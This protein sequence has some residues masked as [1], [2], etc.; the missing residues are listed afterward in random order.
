M[1]IFPEGREMSYMES[2]VFYSFGDES[3]FNSL[4]WSQLSLKQGSNARL[5]SQITCDHLKSVIHVH[6]TFCFWKFH[7]AVSQLCKII[8]HQSCSSW[9]YFKK[10]RCPQCFA[11]DIFSLCNQLFPF[12]FQIITNFIFLTQRMPAFPVAP[13]LQF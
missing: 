6:L 4:I 1:E 13:T 3:L 2:C 8:Q 7:S 12:A 9:F 10:C 11:D 5:R